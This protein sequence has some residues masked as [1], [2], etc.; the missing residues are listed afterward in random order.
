[1]KIL[2]P[3]FLFILFS[4]AIAIPA[5]GQ[6]DAAI[7]ARAQRLSHETVIVDGH[8]D[9]P[10]RLLGRWEDI[11]VRTPGGDFDAV[12]ARAGGLTAP[13]MSIYTSA[14]QDAEGTA[15]ATADT[16]I[17]LVGRMVRTWPDLFALAP[18]TAAVRENMRNGRV[19]LP[20]GME[21]G[22][23]LGS[24]LA[25]VAKYHRA[26][27]RYITLCHGKANRIC[28]SS[29]DSVH[30]WNGLSPFGI[31]VVAEMNRLGIIVDIAHVSDDAFWSVLRNT[32]APVIASHSSCRFY[33][34][35]F[36]R[37]MSDSMIAALG[38]NGGVIM[39]NFGSEFLDTKFQQWEER[40]MALRDSLTRARGVK[41]PDST[42][43][44]SLGAWKKQNPP[45]YAPIRRVAEHIDHVVKIA[46]IDHV[47]FGSDFDGVGD[48]LPVGLKDVSGYPNLIAELLKMGYSDEDVKK[49]SG[50]NLMRVW[51]AV[52]NAAHP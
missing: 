2:R 52:E 41:H 14:E 6:D 34:P 25:N 51:S 50:E 39:I 9:L 33:T 23:P 24:D 15:S 19:S 48:M 31:Q 27:I 22:A 42:V 20:M 32:K 4:A 49:V 13:F 3:V 30:I 46:G 8:I 38:R 11:S 18:S 29:Y 43:A 40:R 1:M 44:A 26:G 28:N 10:S 17:A 12:R 16:M 35:G 21:N 47:G 36:E 45:P 7:I 37:N 5:R